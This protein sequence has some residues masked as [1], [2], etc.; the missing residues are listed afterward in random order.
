VPSI[1]SLEG[2]GS[3]RRLGALARRS[4]LRFQ[5]L[6]RRGKLDRALA[7]GVD[8]A[9]HPALAARA[10]QLVGPRSRRALATSLE[11]LVRELDTGP[12]P[13]LSA[14]A[15]FE[16]EQA[17]EAR[18]SLLGLASALRA[19]DAVRPRGVALVAQLLTDPESSP[20]Y[21][22]SAGG[23]LHL[24]AQAALDHLLFTAAEDRDGDR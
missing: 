23:A 5:T 3:P 22:R 10:A 17:R 7:D 4:A 20:L 1:R 8:P 9:A 19:A 15:P 24:K 12:T 16:R 13:S 2:R 6:V 11:R 14:A 21:V 18:E